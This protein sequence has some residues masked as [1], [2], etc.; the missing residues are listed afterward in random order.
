MNI[1]KDKR[2][3]AVKPGAVGLAQALPGGVE[4][5]AG[6]GSAQAWLLN[7]ELRCEI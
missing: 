4:I 3:E 2:S 5:L 1:Q 6:L 7:A